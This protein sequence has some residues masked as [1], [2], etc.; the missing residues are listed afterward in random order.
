MNVS[1]SAVLGSL[2]WPKLAETQW[3]C[4]K[5]VFVSL[6]FS[7]KIY[8]WDV[9]FSLCTLLNVSTSQHIHAHLNHI[10]ESNLSPHL[11]PAFPW[12][13]P[14]LIHCT[15]P[16]AHMHLHRC[17]NKLTSEQTC[18]KMTL[19]KWLQVPAFGFH[20]FLLWLYSS[21][22]CGCDWDSCASLMIVK[23]CIWLN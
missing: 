7:R 4:T 13:A 15:H 19:L 12:A 5:M 10:D 17:I 9:K 20:L 22:G 16:L 3:I 23:L 6:L 1:S 8:I 21:S 14:L 11:C 18:S 2:V